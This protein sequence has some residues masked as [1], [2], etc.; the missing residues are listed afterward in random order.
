MIYLVCIKII[1]GHLPRESLLHR[2]KLFAEFAPLAH[3]VKTGDLRLFDHV[4]LT[5]QSFYI[6]HEIFL[7]IQMHLR[8][9]ILRSFFK[10]V[11]LIGLR[12][13]LCT[14]GR[15]NLKL[16]EAAFA[17][18]QISG[19]TMDEVECITANLIFHVRHQH[20]NN[21]HLLYFR[22]SS[23]DTFLTKNPLSSSAKRPPFLP[24]AL[25]SKRHAIS[26]CD[27]PNL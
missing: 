18:L 9:L 3:A 1:H 8:N 24:R 2:H 7:L 14:E 25:S 16:V 10:K 27:H 19:M 4:L 5:N 17:A 12:M 6:Q 23:R 11:Y 20:G 26:C 21:D 22:G 15:L 13:A